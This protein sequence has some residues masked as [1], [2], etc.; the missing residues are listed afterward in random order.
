MMKR[1]RCLLPRIRRASERQRACVGH[2]SRCRT[3]LDLVCLLG[4]RMLSWEQ[5][6]AACHGRA[7]L[8]H[9]KALHLKTPPELYQPNGRQSP[10]TDP[11]S[12]AYGGQGVNMHWLG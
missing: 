3:T 11:Y 8:F 9:V 7:S 10:A 6:Q 2:P 1:M 12:A 5:L 4:V